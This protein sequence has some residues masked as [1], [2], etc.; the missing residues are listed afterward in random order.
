MGFNT[1]QT[2]AFVKRPLRL[3]RIIWIQSLSV[4]NRL[5]RLNPDLI[6]NQLF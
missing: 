3:R 1:H 2:I 4:A 5:C 6:L